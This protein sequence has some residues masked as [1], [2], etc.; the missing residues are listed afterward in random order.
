[1]DGAVGQVRVAAELV[2]RGDFGDE[3]G[4]LRGRETEAIAGEDDALGGRDLGAGLGSVK[5]GS[6]GANGPNAGG[7]NAGGTAPPPPPPSGP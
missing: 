7:P 4:V 5:G 6:G 3:R 2:L 1:M